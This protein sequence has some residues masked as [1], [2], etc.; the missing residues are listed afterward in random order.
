MKLFGLLFITLF[1]L[2]PNSD[3]TQTVELTITGIRSSKGQLRIGLFKNQESFKN[4]T[5]AQH[6]EFDKTGLKDGNLTV[7]V[8]LETG[9]I[10]LSL[11]DDENGDSEMNYNF[12]GMPKEGFGFSD[13]Y[14][15]GFTKPTFDDFD[16]ELNEHGKEVEIKVRYIL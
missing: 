11:L 10:G 9:T 2:F 13:Y 12:V 14:H 8:E 15:K 5:A 16:F 1:S 4:E 6:F 3:N 7:Q